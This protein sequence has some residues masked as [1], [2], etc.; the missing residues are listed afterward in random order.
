MAG[1]WELRAVVG[2]LC[3]M[4]LF[5]CAA[6]RFACWRCKIVQSFY[7]LSGPRACRAAPY[8]IT[9]RFICRSAYA[10]RVPKH[11]AQ[12]SPKVNR[13]CMLRKF[14]CHPPRRRHGRK[15]SYYGCF[16]TACPTKALSARVADG[17]CDKAPVAVG[18]RE[19]LRQRVLDQ[20]GVLRRA[21]HSD[22]HLAALG[23]RHRR[24]QR[25]R[26]QEQLAHHTR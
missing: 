18:G 8:T 14:A 19:L 26:R 9:G 10:G 3:R 21:R 20:V 17:H 22:I 7:I 5:L 25:R 15:T 13:P 12:V 24:V 23:R 11:L 6:C 2:T 16:S 1:A 4:L